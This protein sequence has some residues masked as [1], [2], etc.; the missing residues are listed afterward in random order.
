MFEFAIFV[1]KGR[2]VHPVCL[3]AN[4]NKINSRLSVHVF[5]SLEGETIFKISPE[6]NRSNIREF[7][8]HSFS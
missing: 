1:C 6:K 7:K 5:A 3:N 8:L 4:Q 2:V